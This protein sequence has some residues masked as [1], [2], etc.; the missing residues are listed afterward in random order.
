MTYLGWEVFQAVP[1]AQWFIPIWINGIGV[2]LCLHAEGK[3]RS[4]GASFYST[5]DMSKR[6]GC[7]H[8]TAGCCWVMQ[9]MPPPCAKITRAST[10]RIARPG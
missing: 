5:T 9:W 8:P 7:A 2:L 3:Y 4:L 1:T 6:L 10:P